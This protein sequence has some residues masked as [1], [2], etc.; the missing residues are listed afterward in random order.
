MNDVRCGEIRARRK[1]APSIC[2]SSKLQTSIPFLLHLRFW[3]TMAF[4]VYVIR[5]ARRCLRNVCHQRNTLYSFSTIAIRPVE[6]SIETSSTSTPPPPPPFQL[7]PRLVTTR[8]EEHL[9]AAQGRTPIGS[10]RRRAAIQSTS[11]IPFEQLPYQCFQEARKILAADREQKLQHIAEERKRIAKV[12]ATPMEKLGGE[13]SKRNKLHS[14]HMYL[15]Q[16]KILADINDPMVKKRFEDG[17]GA[18][19]FSIL[20]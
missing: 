19:G 16:L 18:L 4:P 3:G 13:L 6:A 11:N 5:P 15:E 1:F 8:K 20:S 17:D 12:V 2:R 7:N 14:M 9:L 10:R